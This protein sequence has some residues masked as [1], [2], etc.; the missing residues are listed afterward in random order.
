MEANS[1][2]RSIERLGSRYLTEY[3]R[4]MEQYVKYLTNATKGGASE[5]TD[6]G[7]QGRYV[8]FAKA[9]VTRALGQF[10]E[11]GLSFYTQ[12]LDG[13]I[14]TSNRFRDQVLHPRPDEKHSESSAYRP[15]RTTQVPAALLFRGERGTSP[16]NSFLAVNNRDEPI[17]VSF[18]V[19]ELV[20]EDGLTRFRP[21][22]SFHPTTCRLEPRAEQ[23]VQCTM[24]LSDE[25][26]AG[27]I[28]RG[29]IQVVG[30]P[31]MAMSVTAQ[32]EEVAARPQPGRGTVI[33]RPV[34]ARKKKARVVAKAATRRN[35]TKIKRSKAATKK[36]PRA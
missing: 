32:V 13:A 9:E 12:W 11:A 15:P 21:T 28:H 17:E 34:P 24:K 35:K 4:G 20:T 19:A 3:N 6:D 26:V 10:S 7:L 8:E 16:S 30:Y 18:D 29:Q 27:K 31:E 23:A 14:A 22:A 25:F 36:R 5:F 33:D 2:A 1:F